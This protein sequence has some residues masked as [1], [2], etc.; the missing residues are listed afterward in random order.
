MGWRELHCELVLI[1]PFLGQFG[2]MRWCSIV[3]NGLAAKSTLVCENV[4]LE[5]LCVA[6]SSEPTPGLVEERAV[7]PDRTANMDGELEALDFVS[8]CRVA[9]PDPNP[10]ACVT[11]HQRALIHE[12]IV[13][14]RQVSMRPSP[15]STISQLMLYVNDF[16]RWNSAS[17][18]ELAA[19]LP[20]RS[21]TD[22]WSVSGQQLVQMVGSG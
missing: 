13:T 15:S 21:I 2:S 1:E 14:G 22:S 17:E 5:D 12:H 3:K 4:V 19:I 7:I 8:W 16:H 9:A 18:V 20:D 11:K 6:V 10:A